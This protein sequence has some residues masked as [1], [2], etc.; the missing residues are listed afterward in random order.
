[1]ICAVACTNFVLAWQAIDKAL[2]IGPVSIPKGGKDCY[3]ER[4]DLIKKLTF[5][6]IVYRSIKCSAACFDVVASNLYAV[7]GNFSRIKEKND[8][9]STFYHYRSNRYTVKL[10]FTRFVFFFIPSFCGY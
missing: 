9:Y 7:A 1:M 6:C 2:A 10:N 8:K 3:D 4:F 5:I